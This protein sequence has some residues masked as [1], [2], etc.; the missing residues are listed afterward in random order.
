MTELTDSHSDSDSESEAE[1]PIPRS[2]CQ[3]PVQVIQGC[4]EHAAE[5]GGNEPLEHVQ[6]CPCLHPCLH[7]PKQPPESQG[8]QGIEVLE[9]TGR[10]SVAEDELGILQSE[11]GQ[12]HTAGD[13]AVIGVVCGVVQGSSVA[14]GGGV[15]VPAELQSGGIELQVDQPRQQNLRHR[16]QGSKL[17]CAI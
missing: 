14:Q 10:D 1:V 12:R 2:C 5:E 3:C 7:I 13:K 4:C 9:P 8:D 17:H 16:K 6:P 11:G 15:E